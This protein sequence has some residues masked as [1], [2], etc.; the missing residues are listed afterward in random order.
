MDRSCLTT[1]AAIPVLVLFLGIGI[2]AI[3]MAIDWTPDQTQ[4]LLGGGI[5]VCGAGVGVFAAVFGLLAGAAF[6]RRLHRDTQQDQ[7]GWREVP[8]LPGYP[9]YPGLLPPPA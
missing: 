5:T 1:L 3:R 6:Y 4:L 2:L 7:P 8:R 9:P